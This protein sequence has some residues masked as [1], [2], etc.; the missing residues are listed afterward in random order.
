M[1]ERQTDVESEGEQAVEVDSQP[2]ESKVKQSAQYYA[3]T[4]TGTDT[5][6]DDGDQDGEWTKGEEISTEDEATDD[7]D[8]T[9]D[10]SDI[11]YAFS[12]YLVT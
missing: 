3:W 12:Y 2:C 7:E 8:I 5:E 1:A 4:S 11:Q 10:Q 9:Q 6:D